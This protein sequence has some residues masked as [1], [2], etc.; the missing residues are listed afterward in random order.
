MD[1][2]K[3]DYDSDSDYGFNYGYGSSGG[4]LCATFFN[5]NQH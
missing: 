4:F 2:R 3:G 1:E 5:L